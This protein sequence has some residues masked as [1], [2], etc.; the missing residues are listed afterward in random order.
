MMKYENSQISLSD[1]QLSYNI[2]QCAYKVHT[3]LGP[4]LLEK[5][6]RTCLAHELRKAGLKAQEEYPVSVQYDSL[7]FEQGFR[8]DILVEHRYVLELK[9]A[10]CFHPNH[11]A[12]TLSYM[13][14]CRVEHG[15]LLNFMERSLHPNGI[16]RLILSQK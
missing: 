16:R 8:I 3:K 15:L 10:E 4:G 6:Y 13:K 7:T 1:R 12:Q 9:V 11:I 5:V 2:L 14:F